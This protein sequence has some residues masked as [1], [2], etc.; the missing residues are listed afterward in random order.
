MPVQFA[1]KTSWPAGWRA[2]SCRVAGSISGACGA[3]SSQ[4]WLAAGCLQDSHLAARQ[5]R[6][7]AE[8]VLVFILP[9]DLLFRFSLD[10][11]N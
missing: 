7:E 6:L 8:P 2:D 3:Y 4:G 11:C 9:G 1:C 10:I 5:G